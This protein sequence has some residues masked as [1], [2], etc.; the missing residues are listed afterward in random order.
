MII[1]SMIIA[2]VPVF[3]SAF[4]LFNGSYY[5]RWFY[6]PVLMLC[7]ATASALEDRH[8]PM[9]REGWKSGGAGPPVLLP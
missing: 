3:N 5:A 4:V 2:V 9:I 8:D 7:V 6:M 1:M